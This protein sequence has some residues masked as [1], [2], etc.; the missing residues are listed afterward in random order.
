MSTE[1]VETMRRAYAAFNDGERV[2][3]FTEFK[4]VREAL[5][6]VGLSE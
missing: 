3:R 4:D 6:A 2:V 5:E 1:N